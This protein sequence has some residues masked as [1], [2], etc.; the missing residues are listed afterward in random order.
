MKY[1]LILLAFISFSCRKDYNVV[2][3]YKIKEPP[4]TYS[5]HCNQIEVTYLE[6]GKYFTQVV[7]TGWTHSFNHKQHTK[8]YLKVKPLCPLSYVNGLGF[9][10][11]G[12]WYNTEATYEKS[13]SFEGDLPN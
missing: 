12:W 7:D 11:G 4:K 8:I 9:V 1:I 2:I 13:G 6:N 3:T 5:L 10:D